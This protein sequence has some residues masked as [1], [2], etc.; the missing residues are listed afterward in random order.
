MI[1]DVHTHV[2]TNLDQLGEE[3]A[4]RL[5]RY[6]LEHW[7]QFDASPSAHERA[8]DCVDGAILI[9]FRSARLGAC[10]PNEF[11][12]D[13]VARGMGRLIGVAGIDPLEPSALT[14]VRQA[15]DLG[16]SGVAVAPACQGF[17]PAHS[18]AMKLYERCVRDSLP[19]F[20]SLETKSAPSAQMEF[21]RPAMW[22][23]V[24]RALPE[25]TIIIGRLGQPWVEETLVLLGKHEHVWSDV[26][27]IV[28]RP[29]QLYHALLSAQQSGVI[30]KLLFGSG[31]PDETP[32]KAIES[33]YRVNSF[34]NAT[35]FPSVPRT[36]L[37]SIVER[38]VAACLGLDIVLPKP[39]A[40]S[41]DHDPDSAEIETFSHHTGSAEAPKTRAVANLHDS[42]PASPP[43]ANSHDPRTPD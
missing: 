23:E 39:V 42:P 36:Q 22:D 13:V 33:L 29:W 30:D 4:R 7:G 32:S 15:I 38:D 24:A 21:A 31:F 1:I 37:R 18:A 27:G 28:S 19:L 8:M 25:L 20:V 35:Q 41:A 9:G 16:L 2:W 3:A 11:I 12:A 6:R 5:R 17:H 43:P 34:S 26:A 10:I 40:A 14:Q